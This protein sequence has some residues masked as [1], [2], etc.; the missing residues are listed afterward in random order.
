MPSRFYLFAMVLLSCANF[1]CSQ[2]SKHLTAA[3]L[4]VGSTPADA[5]IRNTLRVPETDNCEFIK[6]ELNLA[7]T[8]Q[9]PLRFELL[10]R[11]GKSKPNTNGFEDEHRIQL[12]GV[13]HIEPGT[14]ASSRRRAFLLTSERLSQPIVLMEIDSNLF[15]LADTGR[16]MLVGNGGFSYIL[17]RLATNNQP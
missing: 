4:F 10:A 13:Y 14:P 2:T 6:W 7:D 17:N 15:H 5:Y 11:Y 9:H 8:S 3:K 1:S 12:K 16:N